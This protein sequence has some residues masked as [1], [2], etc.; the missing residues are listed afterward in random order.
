VLENLLVRQAKLNLGCGRNLI[1]GWINVDNSPSAVLAKLPLLHT[2]AQR[3][4]S[5]QA[6]SKQAPP[7]W[8]ND[9]IFHDVTRGLPYS[10]RSIEKIYSSHMLEH[11]GREEGEAV[12]RECFRVL[13]AGGIMRLVVPDL[14]FHTRRYLERVAQTGDTDRGPHDD[15]LHNIYGAYLNRRRKG[16]YH[17]Y[18]YDRPTLCTLLRGAGFRQLVQQTYQVSLDSELAQLD[19]RPHESLHIDTL[20]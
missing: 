14:V 18:M 5:G 17:R 19:S 8:S 7:P 3:L 11:L 15:F 13:K 1:E 20:K 6:D 16:A 2:I 10:T 9:I 4:Q 12:I